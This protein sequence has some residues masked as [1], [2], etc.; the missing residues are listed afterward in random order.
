MARNPT[1]PDAHLLPLLL[2]VK[3]DKPDELTPNQLF[4]LAD[5]GWIMFGVAPESSG[6]IVL[7]AVMTRLGEREVELYSRKLLRPP[8]G[9]GE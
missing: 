2:N 8:Q 5:R 3:A 9:L 4:M 1:I 6:G 7:D